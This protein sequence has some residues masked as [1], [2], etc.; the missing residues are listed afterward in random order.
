MRITA[1][2][3]QFLPNSALG[4]IRHGRLVRTPQRICKPYFIDIIRRRVRRRPNMIAALLHRA[5][6]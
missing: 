3:M 5:G 4:A 1:I 6:S 2:G